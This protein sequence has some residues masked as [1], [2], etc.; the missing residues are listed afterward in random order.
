MQRFDGRTNLAEEVA[1]LV[2]EMILDGRLPAGERINEVHLAALIGVSRTPLREALSRLVNEGALTDIPRRGFFVRP[3]TAKEVRAIYPIRAILDPAALRLAGVPA[4][5]KIKTLRKLNAQLA[6]CTKPAEAVRLDDELHLELVS[7]C[8]NPVLI[9][10]IQQFMWR[11]RRY[12]LGLMR[13][14]VN[15]ASAVAT[16]ERIF[17]A[18]EAG[19][20]NRAC[21][22]LEGN[23]S[24]GET[25]ILEWLAAREA[26]EGVGR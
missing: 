20:L 19:D 8:P 3:L 18:L 17:L 26:K 10:L 21:D 6:K 25:P 22:E 16:H 11:T 7:D 15:M 2:R 1:A 5:E 4:P 14:S 12:E 9:E 13:K 24:R 23:M